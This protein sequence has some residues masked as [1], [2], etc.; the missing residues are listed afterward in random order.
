MSKELIDLAGLLDGKPETLNDDGSVTAKLLV[1]SRC[2]LAEGILYDDDQHCIVFTDILGKKFHKIRLG[3]T[4]SLLETFELPKMLCSFGLR[5]SSKEGY[6]C[7]WEDGFQLYDLEQGTALSPM[8]E[9]ECVNP[10]GLPDRLNDGRCDPTGGRFVCGG[11]AGN[12]LAGKGG[13]LK[14]YTCEYI[15][16]KL[17]H[18]PLV[19]KITIANS[20]CWAPNGKTM[21]LADSTEEKIHS[22]EYNQDDGT[23]S[24][25]KAFHA[26][27]VSG[28]HPDGSCVD[29]EGYVWNTTW[30]HG[31]ATALVHR[32]DP[33]TGEVVFTVHLPDSTSQSSCCCFGGK[34]LDILFITSALEGLEPENE[35]HAGGIYAVKLD[36]IRGR[37]E[38]RFITK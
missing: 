11:C 18:Q 30:R 17:V 1:D 35:I 4:N 3:N 31:K 12:Q 5:E 38:I 27:P 21:Y 19:D 24:N 26:K 6:L 33:S 15:N 22:Y 10:L 14:V 9:G 37:K 28:D 29:A 16:G 32:I 13:P 36:N 20:I 7:A 25:K 34:D 23:L 2:H 8:S